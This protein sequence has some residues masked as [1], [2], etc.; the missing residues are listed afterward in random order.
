MLADR[1]P[2]RFYLDVPT[3]RRSVIAR[4]PEEHK[5]DRKDDLR[6]FRFADAVSFN[7]AELLKSGYVYSDW[8]ELED[9]MNGIL[10]KVWPSEMADTSS[11]HA[12]LV[13]DAEVNAFMTGTGQMFIHIGLIDEVQDESTLAAVLCHEL[14]HHHLRHSYQKFRDQDVGDHAAGSRRASERSVAME[15]QADSLAMIWHARSGYDITGILE[16]FR[17]M[18]RHEKQWEMKAGYHGSNKRP[19]H[20]AAKE[21]LLRFKPFYE[22]HQ[23]DPGARFLVNEPLFVSC[24]A[25]CRPE[26][27][28]VLLQGQQYSTCVRKAFIY[29]LFD[30]EE[31]KYVWYIMEAIR[32]MC[33]LNHERWDR[34]FVMDVFQKNPA[35]PGSSSEDH[36]FKRFD[37]DVLCL[38]PKQV[39]KIKA[40][41]YWEGEVKFTTYHE[42][43]IFYQRVGN[44]LDCLECQ[45]TTALYASSVPRIRDSLLTIYTN[46]EG[47]H[48]EFAA[49]LRDGSISHS[50]GSGKLTV[51]TGINAYIKQGKDRIHVRVN[52]AEDDRQLDR[53]TDTLG[54]IF[55]DRSFLSLPDLRS[56]SLEMYL[57]LKELWEF[58]LVSTTAIGART[59][60]HILD[61]RYLEF[62]RAFGVNE[63]EFVHADLGEL[64]AKERDAA[65]VEELALLDYDRI[66]EQTENMR[67]LDVVVTSIRDAEDG[68]MKIRHLGAERIIRSGDHGFHEIA[69]EIRRSI[70]D[71]EERLQT[72]IRNLQP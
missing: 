17:M 21:R 58:S 37:M 60:I 39:S 15:E 28:R 69:M 13:R 27:L 35:D 31:P 50:L 46:G 68:I 40:R 9:L 65:A 16:Q 71:K 10:R 43:F 56:R 48:A 51:F 14:A 5:T 36:L 42:A 45:L 6:N 30:P 20:P 55:K 2:E 49:T 4:I 47:L 38:D 24:K 1:L 41:F 44:L 23:N 18:E 33:Y 8:Q 29:H 63:I 3:L 72:A 22:S 12:Y 64:R 34:A 66:F 19:T 70:N 57:Q 26:I 61:P 25:A 32:R 67:Y 53:L 62:F 52:T 59:D 11:V 7:V 54:L